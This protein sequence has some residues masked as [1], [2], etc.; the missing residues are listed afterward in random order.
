MPC[1][2]RRNSC[3]EKPTRQV[4]PATRDIERPDVSHAKETQAGKSVTGEVTA[5]PGREGWVGLRYEIPGGGRG[6][7]VGAEKR[8]VMEPVP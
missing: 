7:I 5:E 3:T 6:G 1:L 4:T 2:I 8:D